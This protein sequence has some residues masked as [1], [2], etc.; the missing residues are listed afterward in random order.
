MIQDSLI[1]SGSASYYPD[2]LAQLIVHPLR[3]EFRVQPR[4]WEVFRCL[5]RHF[6]EIV[7]PDQILWEVWGREPYMG[8]TPDA[9]RVT[10]MGLRRAVGDAQVVETVKYYGYGVGLG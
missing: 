7:P 5:H 1:T 10:I 2:L 3:G 8:V 4:Q 6:G 9:L